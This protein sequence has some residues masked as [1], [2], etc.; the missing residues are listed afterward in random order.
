MH[1]NFEINEAMISSVHALTASQKSV[2]G[3][4][5]KVKKKILFL[6]EE[7]MYMNFQLWRD[8][9]GCMQNIIPTSTGAAKSLSKIIPELKEKISAIAFRVPIA[10]V[11][12]CDMTFK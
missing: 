1:D 2:D 11:S 4:I 9:R 3:P 10:N 5:G 12:L 8:G 7:F 6:V